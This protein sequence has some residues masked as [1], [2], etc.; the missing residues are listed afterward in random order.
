[1]RQIKSILLALF[2]FL[3][4][5]TPTP[6]VGDS[7]ALAP[8]EVRDARIVGEP[9]EEPAIERVRAFNCDGQ[10][11]KTTVGRSLSQ[12]QTTFFEVEVSAGGLIKGALIPQALQAELEARIQTAL[13]RVLSTNYQ[14]HVSFDI[15]TVPGTAFEHTVTWRETKVRGAIDVVYP[16][17]VARV[18]F[19]KI[20][21]VELYGRDS[22]LLSCGTE[23][24][25]PQATAS[26][27][28][29]EPTVTVAL[30]TASPASPTPPPT[31]MPTAS[32]T[33]PRAFT[34]ADAEQMSMTPPDCNYWAPGLAISEGGAGADTFA[35]FDLTTPG[36]VI[37]D[38]FEALIDD[39]ELGRNGV[40]FMITLTDPAQRQ[41]IQ[42]RDGAFFIVSPENA[43][44]F[45]R[46]RQRNLECRRINVQ[47]VRYP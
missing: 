46:L 27:V 31:R 21:G 10:S 17:G 28:V 5:C 32:P 35:A 18:G 22:Q 19:E 4:A 3:T 38:A 13:G 29:V 30:P 45:Y 24:I 42:L 25:P 34:V 7:V 11:N 16:T 26:Q 47:L 8:Q 6:H 33:V 40:L 20:I 44:G 12:G 14:Q 37:G 1:M 2:L 9:Y 41:T 23:P 43:E 36:I 39:Y 15:D